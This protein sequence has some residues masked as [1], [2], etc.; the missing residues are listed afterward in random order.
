MCVY[1]HG[2]SS[3][4]S[5]DGQ[6]AL[7]CGADALHNHTENTSPALF[8]LTDQA[9]VQVHFPKRTFVISL[10]ID[11]VKDYIKHNRPLSLTQT[12]ENLFSILIVLSH[13]APLCRMPV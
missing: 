10:C 13:V 4:P 11:V 9:V 2:R 12:R 7:T 6:R 3:H 1:P 8:R 5:V